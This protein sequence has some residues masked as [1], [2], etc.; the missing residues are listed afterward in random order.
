MQS[1][2][3]VVA[4]MADSDIHGTQG[5]TMGHARTTLCNCNVWQEFRQSPGGGPIGWSLA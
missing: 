5:W 4:P 2:V 3:F 1:T